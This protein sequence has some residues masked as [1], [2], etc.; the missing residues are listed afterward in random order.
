LVESADSDGSTIALDN[1][2]DNIDFSTNT[3]TSAFDIN[4]AGG[5][6]SS[7]SSPPTIAQG[8]EEDLSA[9]EKIEKLKQQWLDLLP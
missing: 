1:N 7:F 8:T 6:S 5:L 4:T 3:G 9:L 2:I